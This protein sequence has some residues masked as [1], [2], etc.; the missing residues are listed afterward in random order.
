M[1]TL[2]PRQFERKRF[3]GEITLRA[4]PAGAP[5]GA[6]AFDLGQSGLALFTNQSLAKGQ[7][8]EV[9]FPT[10]KPAIQAGLDKR[11]GRVVRSRANTDGNIVGVA[12]AEPFTADEL[13]L[14]ETHWVRT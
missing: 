8:V 13:R 9:T 14:L 10:A 2:I 1:K 11:A 5:L 3:V 6:L 7:L 4:L 12:F